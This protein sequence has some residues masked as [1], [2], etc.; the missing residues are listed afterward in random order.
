VAEQL[1]REII[2]DAPPEVILDALA[3]VNSAPSWS[4]VIKKAEIVD[5]YPDGRPHHV[6]ITIKVIGPADNELLEFRWG[7]DWMVWDARKTAQQHGQHV[8]Y[9]L[10]REGETR[11]RVCFAVT[12]EPAAPYPGFLLNRGRKKV[13]KAATEGLRDFVMSRNGSSPSA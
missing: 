12:M 11:T 3:D 6:K 5:T 1:S 13:L 7:P 4:S 9:N 8:E 10:R 2:I